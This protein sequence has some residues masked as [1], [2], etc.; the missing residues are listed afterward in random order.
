MIEPRFKRRVGVAAIKLARCHATNEARNDRTKGQTKHDALHVTLL[1]VK[2]S[3]ALFQAMFMP[4]Y[5]NRS[6]M[7]TCID[8]FR[9]DRGD[10]FDMRDF[11]ACS[12]V[13]RGDG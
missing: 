9:R 8:R 6:G 5:A 10:G 7:L 4:L 12:T 13:G 3:P 2:A 11:G 1:N